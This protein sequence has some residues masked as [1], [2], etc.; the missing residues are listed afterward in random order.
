MP[1]AS[2][3]ICLQMWT[4]LGPN[5]YVIASGYDLSQA[6]AGTPSTVAVYAAALQ[7]EISG[8]IASAGL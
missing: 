8:L 7:S 4:A 5:G 2:H 3:T 1:I 6:P